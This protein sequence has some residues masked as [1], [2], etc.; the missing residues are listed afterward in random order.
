GEHYSP[1]M[2]TPCNSMITLDTGM[3]VTLI[4]PD[5]PGPYPALTF[6]RW[7]YQGS[8]EEVEMMISCEEF[9]LEPDAGEGL[10]W[11]GDY[12]QIT[13]SADFEDF[14]MYCGD[15]GPSGVVSKWIE[16]KFWSNIWNNE[17]DGFNCTITAVANTGNS[18]SGGSIDVSSSLP[19]PVSSQTK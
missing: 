19:P 8:S 12:L 10:C 15:V 14:E 7:L 11:L 13:K 9:D 16:A 3:T 1:G 18:T 4:S 2:F 5:Y 17:F 6:C